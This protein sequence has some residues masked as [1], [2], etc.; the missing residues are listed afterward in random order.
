MTQALLGCSWLA[1]IP[2]RPGL[3]TPIGNTPALPKWKD[4]LVKSVEEMLAEE[5][6]K[7]NV[8]DD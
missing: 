8:A 5:Q 4:G 3:F 6:N 2:R 7:K 1:T